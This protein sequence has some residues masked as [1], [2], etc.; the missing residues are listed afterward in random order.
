MEFFINEEVPGYFLIKRNGVGSMYDGPR[1]V[2]AIR[3]TEVTDEAVSLMEELLGGVVVGFGP[4]A[5]LAR[6]YPVPTLDEGDD[7]VR[8]R[9]TDRGRRHFALHGAFSQQEERRMLRHDRA[10]GRGLH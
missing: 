10:D 9:W 1:K 6:K 7:G 8:R 2:T 5:D 4:L 3:N